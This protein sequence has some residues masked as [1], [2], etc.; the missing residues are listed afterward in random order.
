MWHSEMI[1]F[2][3]TQGQKMVVSCNHDETAGPDGAAKS[4]EPVQLDPAGTAQPLTLSRNE[5]VSPRSAAA[6]ATELTAEFE[7]CFPGG[8]VIQVELRLPADAFR[9]WSFWSPGSEVDDATMLGRPGQAGARHHP[10][11]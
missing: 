5:E 7:K 8:P 6:A 9:S 4:R 3:P 2:W 10:C 1:A 11:R